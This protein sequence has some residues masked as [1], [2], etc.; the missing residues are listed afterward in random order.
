MGFLIAAIITVVYV[1]F[2]HALLRILSD[3]PSVV[4]AA[5][6]YLPWAWSIPL[7]GTAAFL[8]DGVFIGLTA[9]RRMMQAMA[10]ASVTFFVLYFLLREPLGNHG[11]WTAFMAYMLTRGGVQTLFYFT[12]KLPFKEVK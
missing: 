8:W 9:G 10:A 11:L 12:G 1:L 6:R 7:A 3:E 2:G 5:G 4:S